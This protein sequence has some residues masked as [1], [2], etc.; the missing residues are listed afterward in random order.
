MQRLMGLE[1]EYGIYI[2][3]VDVSQLA[4]ATRE[5]IQTI[6]SEVLWDYG[7]E[8]PL[9][10]ARGF[11]A[12]S[13]TTNPEDDKVEK[14]SS[15][16]RPRNP[17]EDHVDRVLTNGAR[18]YH[19]H[20]HP[21]YS[22]P[23]CLGI[24]D[25]VAHDR[26]GELILLETARN[27]GEQ[28]GK[29]AHIYKNNTDYH[30]MS[31]GHHE[32]YLT[33][34]ALNFEQLAA[35]LIPFFVTRMI[36]TG[37]GKVGAERPSSPRD[38]QYQLSQRAE[39][40]DTIMSVDTLHRRPLINTRDEPHCDPN[41]W[42]RLHVICGDANLSEY[43]TALKVGTASLVL[44]VLESGMGP[45][46]EISDPIRAIKEISFDPDWK[47]L[48][49]TADGSEV[50]AVEI[51]RAYLL[52]AR[53]LFGGRDDETDWVLGEWAQVLDE[54]ESDPW[55]L[56]DRLDWVAKLDLLK[57]FLD[58]EDLD[59]QKNIEL[60]RSLE[61]EYHNID[62]L[63]GLFWPLEESGGVQRLVSDEQIERAV[64]YAPRNTRAALRGQAIRM[65]DVHAANWHRVKIKQNEELVNID[66]GELVSH[67]LNNYQRE[68]ENL[69]S[70]EDMLNWMEKFKN[71]NHAGGELNA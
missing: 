68:L 38:V 51:Q 37:A 27:Y 36:Y 22:T 25:L 47:W 9:R 71:E 18:L 50:S 19:D 48:V 23:E 69:N 2:D 15:G 70:L 65:L 53:E 4:D 63:Q 29:A 40:F 12:Q 46:V 7:D 41:Q 61:L 54:L 20:G 11:R 31:Y 66:L 28:T 62:R 5:L 32:S 60:L 16:F 8:H 39:F 49:K 3:G 30:G 45:P 1:T 35:G 10:D 67:N 33:V 24:H 43:A 14:Q 34:R 52:T 55:T 6:Q 21:E 57:S 58:A 42:R 17:G 44:D 13:L 56:R 64:E 26:A 59:W